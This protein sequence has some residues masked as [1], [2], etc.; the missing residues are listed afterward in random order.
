MAMSS[1]MVSACWPLSRFDMAAWLMPR[2]DAS[3]TC[4]RFCRARMARSSAATRR[5]M[6]ICIGL[7][8]RYTNRLVKRIDIFGVS[9]H[10][11]SVEK[12]HLPVDRLTEALAAELRA[13]RGRSRIS[14]TTIAAAIGRSQS[15]VSHTLN[16]QLSPSIDELVVICDLLGIRADELLARVLQTVGPSRHAA[17][18]Y[19]LAADDNPSYAIEDIDADY[20]SA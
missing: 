11:C 20:D 17:S 14:Q 3:S 9:L 7:F 18:T 15:Y 13:E 2:W 10:F 19:A 16:G 6:S 8:Y 4:F 1:S 12:H 5:L